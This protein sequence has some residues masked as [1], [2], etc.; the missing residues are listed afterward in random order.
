MWVTA[1]YLLSSPI[2]VILLPLVKDILFSNISDFA[3]SSE[4]CLAC[5]GQLEEGGLGRGQLEEGGLGR[6]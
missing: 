4:G 1:L 2:Y 5:R 6:G 3:S